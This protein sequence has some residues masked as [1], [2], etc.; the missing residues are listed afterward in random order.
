MMILTVTGCNNDNEKVDIYTSIYPVYFIADYIVDDNLV[1]KQIYPSGADVHEYD[2]GN[3]KDILKMRSA[4]LMFYIGA[5]LEAFIY[6]TQSIFEN[7][8][9]ELVELSNYVTLCKQTNDGFA[10]LTEEELKNNKAIADTHIW[11]DPIRMIEMTKIISEKIIAIDPENKEVYEENTEKLISEFY[12]LDNEFSLKLGDLTL[13]KIILVDH[14]SYL[15][16]EERYGVQRIRTRDNNES[17]EAN[18]SNINEV[19]SLAQANNIKYI[20]TTENETVCGIIDK[21]AET[22]GAQ[23]IKLNHLS[24]LY[25]KDI[26]DGK[27]YFSIMRSNLDKLVSILPKK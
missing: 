25:K 2:P 1:V 6:K 19:I 5:G 9:I 15:Y 12:K 16:W 10:Y 11:L 27:D 8:P 13:K 17:C 3:G 22:L 26:Q 7:Q 21:Y 4:K 20:V 24:T 18:P 23:I 14:D